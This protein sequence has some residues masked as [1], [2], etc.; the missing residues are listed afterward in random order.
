[1]E[2]NE[3][4]GPLRSR[5]LS[6]SLRESAAEVFLNLRIDWQCQHREWAVASKKQA[7]Y[8]KE[9]ALACL[10]AATTGLS[11]YFV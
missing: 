1:M 2:G 10:L 5:A 3:P 11:V 6:W 8:R 7:L 4:V 9:F